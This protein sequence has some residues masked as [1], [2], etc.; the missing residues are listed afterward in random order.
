LWV[1]G[2][3][4]EEDL[5]SQKSDFPSP[6]PPSFALP[7]IKLRNFTEY[8]YRFSMNNLRIHLEISKFLQPQILI[9]RDK[10][11]KAKFF[12]VKITDGRFVFLHW[13][14]F[15][16]YNNKNLGFLLPFISGET[17]II[18]KLFPTNNL[19]KW[20]SKRRER[21]L[22]TISPHSSIFFGS[23]EKNQ[24]TENK[25]QNN[26]FFS[27]VHPNF[28]TFKNITLWLSWD[29][30]TSIRKLRSD[31]TTIVENEKKFVGSVV[32]KYKSL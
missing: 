8:F 17:R 10:L 7:K 20:E 29:F 9:I 11:S 26:E 12:K 2:F 18:L 6:P 22:S 21:F 13:L 14:F 31:V 23:Y 27:F 32:F 1:G 30:I 5:P 16:R 19:R 15:Q 3:S 24:K 25:E 28:C 4:L